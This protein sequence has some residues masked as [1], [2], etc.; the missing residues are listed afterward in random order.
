MNNTNLY[1]RSVIRDEIVKLYL[2]N[3]PSRSVSEDDYENL[4]FYYSQFKERSVTDWSWID[5]LLREVQTWKVI[6]R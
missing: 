6:K 3:A 5:E 4:T 1:L 2:K